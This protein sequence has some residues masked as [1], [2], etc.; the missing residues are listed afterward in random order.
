MAYKESLGRQ[1]APHGSLGIFLFFLVGYRVVDEAQVL[2]LYTALVVNRDVRKP[3]ITHRMAGKA[4]NRAA[5]CPC[6]AHLNVVYPNA[7]DASY[8]IYGNQFA[9]GVIITIPTQHFLLTP[10]FIA[11]TAIAQPDKDGRLCTLDGE[12]RY[13]DILQRAAID[14]FKRD[15]RCAYPLS[16]ELLLLVAARL[17][18]DARD[19]DVAESPVRLCAQLYGITMTR[20]HTIRDA[21]IF[22]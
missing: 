17:Y 4:R 8:V 15:G 6:I 19:V 13:A 10:K 18:D 5:C 3:H 20:H 9:Y 11:P 21:D 1:I 7:I 14:D 16:E 12:V 22:T 2:R